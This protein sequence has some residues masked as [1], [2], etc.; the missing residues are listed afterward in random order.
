VKSFRAYLTEIH[1]NCDE[2][3][4][5]AE[6]SVAQGSWDDASE[7]YSRFSQELNRHIAQEENILFPS[8]ENAMNMTGG[9]T[10]VMRAEHKQMQDILAFMEERLVKQDQEG[11][12]GQSET[13]LIL[14]QQH[15]QKEENILYPMADHLLSSK[16]E[17]IIASMQL[18]E[19]PS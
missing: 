7:W 6:V 10:A 9:P 3:F 19:A 5:Q 16:R 18:L 17:Q 14:L 15:N 8:L 11:Y 1:H 12:L 13:L 2:M 4:A